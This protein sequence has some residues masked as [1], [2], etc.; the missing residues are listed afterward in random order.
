MSV[1]YDPGKANVVADA[2]SRLSMG[3]VT[4]IEDEKKELVCDVHRLAQ[5]DV[6]SKQHLVPILME[7]KESVFGKSI[8][9][10]FQRG[11]GVLRYQGRLCVPD[12]DGL[13]EKILEE[14]HGSR[15]FIHLGATKMYH[16]LWE[17]YWWNGM[18]KDIAEFVAKC[19]NCQQVK[20]EHRKPGGFLQDMPIPTWKWEEFVTTQA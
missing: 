14:A 13:R 15:Y 3:S 7:L 20:V 11:D 6:K 4:H 12:M 9:V 2:L 19:P 5:L 17:V 8:E 1:L 18:K 16:D 10:F